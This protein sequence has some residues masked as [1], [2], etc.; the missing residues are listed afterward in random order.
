MLLYHFDFLDGIVIGN[1][2]VIENGNEIEKE[3][4]F[5]VAAVPIVVHHRHYHSV[6]RIIA[7]TIEIE[8]GTEIVG[9]ECLVTID[10]PVTG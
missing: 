5:L 6:L 4:V 9:W 2:V 8:I 1:E 10:M 3:I 7:H